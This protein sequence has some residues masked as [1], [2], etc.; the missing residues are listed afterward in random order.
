[1]KFFIKDCISSEEAE[2][3]IPLAGEPRYVN[4]TL[5]RGLNNLPNREVFIKIFEKI[6]SSI[7]ENAGVEYKINNGIISGPI[8]NSSYFNIEKGTTTTYLHK[9]HCDTG[10]GD[11]MKWCKFGISLLLSNPNTFKG[12]E[13]EY[14][15]CEQ[16]CN[17]QNG[18]NPCPNNEVILKESHY[19][20]VGIHDSSH[21]H[22]LRCGEESTD[23]VREGDRATFLAFL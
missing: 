17:K 9:W 15:N 3:I 1:M 2:K 23:G 11:H 6:F 18:V 4:W 13:L 16:P 21:F 22:R 20:G 5:G 8:S 7:N 10:T 12:A 14:C 19:L